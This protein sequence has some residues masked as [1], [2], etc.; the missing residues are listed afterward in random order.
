MSGAIKWAIH[1]GLNVAGYPNESQRPRNIRDELAALAEQA[2]ELSARMEAISAE[3]GE[4]LWA[5]AWARRPTPD[6]QPVELEFHRVR[7][8]LADLHQTFS[9]AAILVQSEIRPGKWDS[10]ERKQLKIILACHLGIVFEAAFP[11]SRA[12]PQ[13]GCRRCADLGRMG[14]LLFAGF[15]S[16]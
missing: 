5:L 13:R 12:T 9:D 8:G 1:R 10:A 16:R 2:R 11:N 3:A 6:H 7:D 14:G 15:E 4:A